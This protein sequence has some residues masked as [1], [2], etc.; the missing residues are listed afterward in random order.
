M[1]LLIIGPPASGKGTQAEKLV[2]E[3]N[4]AHVE[5]G[6]MLREIGKEETALGEKVKKFLDEGKLATDD[7]VAEVVSKH[8]QG[9]GRID[10][11]LFD[12]FPR[13]VSQAKYL[14][15]FM[16]E[17]DLR[18]DVVIYLTLSEEEIYKRLLNR[19]TCEQCGKVFNVVTNPP[20][21]EGVC[22]Y[23]GGKLVTRSDES[24]EKTAVRIQWFKDQVVPMIGFYHKR[25]TVEEIDGNRPIET[26][27]EDIQERLAKR[28][29]VNS[30]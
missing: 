16:K 24:P 8:L 30:E 9:L 15:N 11:I 25:G 26:I 18:L 2:N 21:I 28:G 23:C 17:K 5:M 14:E 10:G 3:Y 19:R 4:L 12:G 22:D 7:I 6:G 20:K 27:F 29:L 13:I 1:N